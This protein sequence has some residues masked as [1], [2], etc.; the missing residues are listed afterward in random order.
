[1]LIAGR[2]TDWCLEVRLSVLNRQGSST[3]LEQ[4]GAG[5]GMFVVVQWL[6]S[7]A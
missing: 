5:L 3:R 4:I 6:A 2:W 7:A 1:M